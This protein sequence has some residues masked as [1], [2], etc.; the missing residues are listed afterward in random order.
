MLRTFFS[1]ILQRLEVIA[2]DICSRYQRY[3]K[4][5]QANGMTDKDREANGMG[6]AGAPRKKKADPEGKKGCGRPRK[7]KAAELE[8][9]EI[10]VE[11]AA[12]R[13]KSEEDTVSRPESY[14]QILGLALEE[15]LTAF[16]PGYQGHLNASRTSF[17]M[18]SW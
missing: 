6:G 16:L 4:L 10:P 1:R 2:A 9:E 15:V 7:R 13:I 18:P 12:K 8:D 14:R 11:E 5:C 3:Y 17:G